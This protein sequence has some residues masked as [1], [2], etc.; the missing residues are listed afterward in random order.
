MLIHT[1][2]V[3]NGQ[4]V[5]IEHDKRTTMIDIH[6]LSESERNEEILESAYIF[7]KETAGGYVYAATNP[8][9]YW[10]SRIVG[11]AFRTIITHPDQDHVR[12]FR[13]FYEKVGTTNLWMTTS[14]IDTL[15]ATDDGE[16]IK[17][18]VNGKLNGVTFIEPKRSSNNL[19]F[20]TKETDWDQIQI[21]HP[22]SSY[23]A[24][25]TNQG[26]YLIKIN[27]GAS[28]VIIGGDTE[29]ET[30]EWLYKEHPDELKCTIF[31]ASHHG[32][33]SGWPGKEI[34]QHM[35][36]LMVVIPKGKILPKDS[37]LGNY[38][39]A[40]GSERFIT[41]SYAGNV[42][43]KLS[44]NDDVELFECERYYVNSQIPSILAK[45]RNLRI[46]NIL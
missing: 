32:R 10:K 23:V 17:R 14:H 34:I 29:K 25:S 12:G 19:Y 18:I 43:I 2:H 3:K 46:N 39:N 26:S 7:Q 13:E 24:E 15:P 4:C 20:G 21:L 6:K 35:N 1:L 16:F 9:D 5:I 27:Y 44:K 28:S 30:F 40:L 37:A 42:R 45:A 31:I 8:I 41:T 11:P 36:P 38:R 22:A 33:Q